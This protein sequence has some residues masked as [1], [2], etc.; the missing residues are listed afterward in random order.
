MKKILFLTLCCLA[1]TALAAGAAFAAQADP[2]TKA[3]DK[4]KVEQ[5]KE[6]KC[7]VCSAP[8]NSKIAYTYQGKAYHFCCSE[9]EKQFKDSPEKYLKKTESAPTETVKSQPAQP[10]TKPEKK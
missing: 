2:Q 6:M 4:A 10:E 3:A 1:L 9:C 8:A 7:P 5:A